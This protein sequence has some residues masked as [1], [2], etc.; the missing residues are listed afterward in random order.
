MKKYH[1]HLGPGGYAAA[2]PKWDAKE[3]ELLAKGI[4]PEPIREEWDLRARNWFLGH[5]S[6]YDESTGDLI[7]SDGIRIPRDTWQKVV[8]E[9]KAG[10]T[11]FRPDREKDLLTKVLGNDERGG[12]VRGLGPSYTWEMGFPKDRD[13]YRSRERAKRRRQE[14]E[15]D[16]FTELIGT[17][18]MHQQQIDE[19]RGAARLQDPVLDITA[20]PSQRKSSVA[21]S[22]VP[23]DDARMVDGGPGYPVDGIKE[24]ASCELH[25]KVK[26]LSIKVAVGCA[27][28]CPP[29]ARW[30]GREI[31]AGYAKVGV[32]EIAMGWDSMELD[33]P[34]P[35]GERTLGEVLGG[36]ILWDKNNIKLPGWTPKPTPPPSGRMS[37]SPPSPP[38]SPPHD[39]DHHSPSPSRSPPQPPISTKRRR[40]PKRQMSPLPR[41]P[42]KNLPIRPYDRTDEE[43]DM[44]VKA[45]CVAQLQ[46]KKPEPAPV[47]TE[48]QKA[49]AL[50]FLNTKSQYDLHHKPDDYRRT[51]QKEVKKSKSSRSA[52][53]SKSSSQSATGKRKDVP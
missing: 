34:G 41:V 52:S 48:K 26:N 28:P 45:E 25:Q 24:Q 44:I 49:Y 20:V 5:G 4:T 15:G 30:H 6:E 12:R 27:L 29:G 8:K 37:P 39:Y 43:T 9:I 19:L 11:K 13:T 50:S 40:S 21:E 42:H 33:I 53:G 23:S 14:E 35:E 7:C 18:R 3:N 17:L 32:D 47:Y 22:E 46:K 51:L 31:P 36:I 16:K 38:R 2:M 1:H 10:T